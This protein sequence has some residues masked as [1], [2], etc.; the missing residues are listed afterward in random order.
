MNL[1]R[2]ISTIDSH[3]AG[4][5]TRII[6]DGAPRLKGSTMME[7]KKDLEKNH[8]E[9]RTIA[10]NEPRGHQECFGCIL[11]EP[12]VPEADTGVIFMDPAGCLNMCGHGSI[13]VASVLVETGRVKVTEPYTTVCL[14]TP[15]GLVHVKVKVENGRA[16]EATMEGVPSFIY[17]EDVELDVPGVGIVKG[18]VAFGGSFFFIFEGKQLGIEISRKNVSENVEKALAIMK[19]AN[20]VLDIKHPELDIDTIDLVE[21]YGPP[22]HPDADLQNMVVLGEGQTDRSPCGTG[23]SAKLSVL[24][25]KGKLKIGEKFVHESVL[26]TLFTGRVLRETKVGSYDAIIPEITGS[27]Y[28]TGY[29]DMVVDETDP[30]KNGFIVEE[31]E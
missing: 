11:A 23:T 5:P 19:T 13:G 30:L 21:I 15:A 28:I 16:V 6:V 24:Y 22:K 12:T 17:K 31:K 2:R 27:A 25:K 20:D 14:E 10:M 29:Y 18:D 7:K 8:P 26:G 4:A 1:S 3:T 9:I